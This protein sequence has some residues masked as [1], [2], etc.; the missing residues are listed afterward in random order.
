VPNVAKK[1]DELRRCS[2]RKEVAVPIE[3]REDDRRPKGSRPDGEA[4]G[5]APSKEEP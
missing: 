3:D 1:K 2:K 4:L 5:A